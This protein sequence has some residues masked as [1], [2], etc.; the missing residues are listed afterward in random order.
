[1]ST[2]DDNGKD[3]RL[4]HIRNRIDELDQQLQALIS[5][6]AACAQ[7][8]AAAKHKAGTDSG[9]FYRPEREAQI[10]RRV[11]SRNRGPLTN[12]TLAQLFREIISVCL[13]LEAPLKVAF[14][15]PA[16]TY[17]QAATSKHFGQAVTT[18]ACNAVD[19]V[20][21]A[22]E[23]DNAH[24]GVV[25]VENSTEGAISHTLDM[26]LH[27]NLRICGEVELRIHHCLLGKGRKL[28]DVKKVIAHQQSLAQCRKW[29]SAH[30]PSAKHLAVHSNAE[31]AR[32]VKDKHTAAIAGGATAELYGLK[33]LAAN[34]EDEA[35]N[36]TRFVVVGKLDTAPSGADKTSLLLS[37]P[38]RPGALYQ[39][40]APLARRSISMNRIESRP[41]RQGSWEY[42]FFIDIDGHAQDPNVR[43]ALVELE[44]EAG[45][46]KWLGSYPRAVA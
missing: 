3:E 30:L 11:L 4:R 22:V 5:Q 44:R 14:L 28:A 34:I 13:A 21:R 12:E 19:E 17:T 41:A 23:S 16:G 18:L 26:F 27:S 8:I 40:L 29:L 43:E 46:L 36:T 32:L 31:A 9:S 42:V 39:M 10:L 20:F 35:H 37:A 6:R 15:G 1:M 38:N 2:T 24:F 25:P 33:V 7:E 45:F